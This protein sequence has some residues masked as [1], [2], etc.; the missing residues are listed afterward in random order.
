MLGVLKIIV[1]FFNKSIQFHGSQSIWGFSQFTL[2]FSIWTWTC[3]VRETIPVYRVHTIIPM[4]YIINRFILLY[5]LTF[6]CIFVQFTTIHGTL[7]DLT[8]WWS[9]TKPDFYSLTPQRSCFIGNSR[10]SRKCPFIILYSMEVFFK[11]IS[12]IKR[13]KL[14][15]FNSF[16][17]FDFL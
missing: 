10:F 12:F 16:Y 17:S 6:H 8:F 1:N 5:N 13:I 2:Y 14:P 4:L 7:E 11:H 15:W 3:V 9:T